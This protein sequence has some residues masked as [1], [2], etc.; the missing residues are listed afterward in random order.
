MFFD[1]RVINGLMFG[2]AHSDELLIEHDD[3]DELEVGH[4]VV[5]MILCWQIAIIFHGD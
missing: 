3:S 1:V 2:I 4:G 5:I